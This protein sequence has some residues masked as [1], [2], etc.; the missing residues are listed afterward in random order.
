MLTTDRISSYRSGRIGMCLIAAMFYISLV[1]VTLF[2]P[3]WP[4]EKKEDTDAVLA[5][6]VY[7]NDDDEVRKS[8]V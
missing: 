3:D 1:S 8:V 2:V 6:D 7:Y 4:D 5:N